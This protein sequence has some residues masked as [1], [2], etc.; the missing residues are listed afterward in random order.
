MP[1][2]TTIPEWSAPSRRRW[3][4]G[5]TVALLTMLGWTPT[6]VSAGLDDLARSGD[7]KRV[8]EV[9]SRRADQLP[10]NTSE[11]MIAA[12]AARILGERKPE[13]RFLL[14]V[15]AGD[16]D[17]LRRLAGVQ[18]AQLVAAA[19]PE[20]AA[21]LTVPALG[22]GIPSQIR[23][24][25][26]KIAKIVIESGLEPAQRAAI[27]GAVPKLPRGL[28]RD[29]ELSLAL[30]DSGRGRN[31]LERLLAGS[32]ADLVALAAAE[33]LLRE[34]SL[35]AI[36]QWRVANALY[37]HA[38]YDR[39]VPILETLAAT[40][41]GSIPRDGPL[42]LL[43]RCAFR[44]DRWHEAIV[45][46]RLALA[47]AATTGRRAEIEVH[48]G[49][50]FELAGDLEE[51]QKAAV[52]AVQIK[53][54]DDRR[55]FLARLRLRDGEPAL[56]A[57]GIGQIRT[58][59]DRDRGEVMLAL[60]DLR[61]GASISA[62]RRLG[63]IRRPPWA[64]PAA[65]VVAEIAVREGDAVGALEAL[66]RAAITA[67][68][69]WVRQARAVMATLPAAI[70]DE[71]RRRGT[72]ESLKATERTQWVALGRLA[73]LEPD[74]KRRGGIRRSVSL[75]LERFAETPEPGFEPG[76]AS[77]LW[78]LG[79][80][81][82][83]AR[84]D[85]T[86]WPRGNAAASAWS[87]VGLLELGFP[88]R[89]TRVADGAWRQAGNEVP[90]DVLPEPLR[91][92]LNPL[93][94]PGLVRELAQAGGVDWNLLAAVVREESRWDPRALSAVGAR[95]LVQL[96][97]ATAVAVA[98]SI[99]EPTPAAD[100]LFDPRISLRLGA[101]ELGRLV[102]VFDGRRAPAVAAYNAGEVQA[103][104]WLDQCGSGCTDAH[105]LLNI[106]FGSTRAYTADVVAA[107]ENYRELYTESRQ[108][109]AI[110]D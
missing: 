51:A 102:K 47:Q 36:E 94:D 60:D 18:L 59:S 65:V 95:G 68:G 10:L 39:A 54:T 17:E 101:A 89:A 110:S 46:Y 33:A 11:A 97:P 93:P 100:D 72:E 4:T 91:R 28:R 86:G 82:E 64:A 104:V 63:A 109:E 106:S 79:L 15:I 12:T 48:I 34:G 5:V 105:Y 92:A 31:R 103:R 53:T 52:R 37:R 85:P 76:L 66:E 87:A 8:L 30:T 62:Q 16:N 42:F 14:V 67:D 38:M 29:L 107:A 61:R 80:E 70:V 1:D 98:A 69:F 84:W 43:G 77:E 13:A 57:Q 21:E 75:A 56:A 49:R 7:W 2:L 22:R 27:E 24:A 25:A 32:T 44:R 99:G 90:T 58:R 83:A 45:W 108:P 41:G 88:W 73:A 9:A 6:A 19:E 23:E 35:T 55:L 3:R 96:M 50:C 78:H 40:K 20:K 74:E 81:R 26:T 71:W